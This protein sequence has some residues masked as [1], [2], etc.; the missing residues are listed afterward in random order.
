MTYPLYLMS[1]LR[2]GGKELVDPLKR[3]AMAIYKPTSKQIELGKKLSSG[4]L[5]SFPLLAVF[6]NPDLNIEDLDEDE[7]RAKVFDESHPFLGVA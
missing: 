2:G 3:Q 1:L 6:S 7:L 4:R 5:N